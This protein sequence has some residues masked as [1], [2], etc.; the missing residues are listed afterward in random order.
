MYLKTKK[1][2]M[3]SIIIMC[4]NNDN[5]RTISNNRRKRK[6]FCRQLKT[7]ARI[8]SLYERRCHT[9][10]EMDK[11]KRRHKSIRWNKYN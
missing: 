3:A 6:P 1:S 11:V 4:C 2:T 8:P 9:K 7:T 10:N 5:I